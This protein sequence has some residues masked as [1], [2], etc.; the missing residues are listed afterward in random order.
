MSARLSRRFGAASY[1]PPLLE[2]PATEKLA[3]TRRTEARHTEF[4]DLPERDQ[5][6][7]LEAEA[8]LRRYQEAIASGRPDALDSVGSDEGRRRGRPR[9]AATGHTRRR[10]STGPAEERR[11]A[12][13]AERAG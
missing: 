1:Y 7:I 9:S 3:L 12:V 11:A 13:I 2:M 6:L 10:R 5:R 4:E 8:N